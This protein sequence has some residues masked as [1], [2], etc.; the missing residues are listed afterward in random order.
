MSL[1]FYP[2]EEPGKQGGNNPGAVTNPPGDREDAAERLRPHA[3]TCGKKK[4]VICK[5]K[6]PSPRTGGKELQGDNSTLIRQSTSGGK[7]S[8]RQ[9]KS[10]DNFLTFVES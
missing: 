2:R 1:R 5:T 4:R 9:R 10:R 8:V 3:S 6:P 7:W